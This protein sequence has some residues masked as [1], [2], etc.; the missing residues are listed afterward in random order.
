MSTPAAEDLFTR[1]D[2]RCGSLGVRA[3]WCSPEADIELGESAPPRAQQLAS[4]TVAGQTAPARVSAA[5]LA[6]ALPRRRGAQNLGVAVAASPA[7]HP[8]LEE[9]LRRTFEDLAT[10]ANDA[11]T[12]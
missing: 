7:H 6:I 3:W 10:L 8:Q 1:F 2:R 9:V 4:A 11:E 5:E 12:R